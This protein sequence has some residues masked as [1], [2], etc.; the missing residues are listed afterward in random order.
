[1]KKKGLKILNRFEEDQKAILKTKKE[2][3]LSIALP[4]ILFGLLTFFVA[5]AIYLAGPEISET[6]K[7]IALGSAFLSLP[8]LTIAHQSL[9]AAYEADDKL[10]ELDEEENEN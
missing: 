2:K 8:S 9:G 1:M 4:S 5:G 10:A 3:A 6:A 7:N